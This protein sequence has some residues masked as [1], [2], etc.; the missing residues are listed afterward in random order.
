DRGK[1]IISNKGLLFSQKRV[2]KR[3]F[4]DVWKTDD[5]DRQAHILILT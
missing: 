1:W 5:A 3:R 4:T 2:K